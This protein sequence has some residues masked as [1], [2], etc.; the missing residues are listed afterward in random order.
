MPNQQAASAS[1]DSNQ[2]LQALL[3]LKDGD[4]SARLPEPRSGPEREIAKAFNSVAALNRKL[5]S[6]LELASKAPARNGKVQRRPVPAGA[7]GSWAKAFNSV[8]GI[9]ERVSNS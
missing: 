9:I 5:A 8:N 7:K 3:A 1:Y 4:F 6:E 2:L